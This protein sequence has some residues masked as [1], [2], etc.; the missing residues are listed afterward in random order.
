MSIDRAR[1]D[2]WVNAIN[3]SPAC[4]NSGRG[5]DCDF[6]F[7]IATERYTL[8]V[9]NG[10]IESLIVNGG[11]LVHS[12]FSLLADGPTWAALLSPAP[13]NWTGTS[14]GR[15]LAA[16][17]MSC[18]TVCNTRSFTSKPAAAYPCCANTPQATQYVC[19]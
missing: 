8:Q 16:T 3:T 15:P 4:A 9:R 14:I 19:R 7:V 17:S 1:I 18:S 2:R 12:A 10:H 13:P 6:T 11:P 5:F